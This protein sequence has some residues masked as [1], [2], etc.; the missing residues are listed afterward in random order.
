MDAFEQESQSVECDLEAIS[1]NRSIDVFRKGLAAVKLKADKAT[2]MRSSNAAIFER[3]AVDLILP[4]FMTVASEL[5]AAPI[6]PEIAFHG[7]PKEV[8]GLPGDCK[9]ESYTATSLGQYVNTSPLTHFD[10]GLSLTLGNCDDH[11]R[12]DRRDLLNIHGLS[13]RYDSETGRIG[14]MS[15]SLDASSAKVLLTASQ[16]LIRGD[17]A[18]RPKHW[19]DLDQ[20]S[21]NNIKLLAGSFL[22][23]LIGRIR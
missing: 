6:T 13:M 12:N 21:E 22:E 15:V 3:T 16:A 5:A 17:L 18:F 4:V 20:L 7:F 9:R 19:I 10:R 1:L 2:V 23:S 8:P 11:R 14:F